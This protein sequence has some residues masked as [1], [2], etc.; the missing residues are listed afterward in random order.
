M[1]ANASLHADKARRHV[2]K[3]R[4]YLAARP[5]LA[6]HNC[7]AIIQAND[8]ERVLTDIDA[9]YGDRN[10]CCRRHSVLLV[11]APLASLSLVGQE[12]GRTIPSADLDQCT[13]RSVGGLAD[14]CY[15]YPDLTI[16]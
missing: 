7:T 9:D 16:F 1:R 8:V 10:L 11:L 3:S 15:P 2:G 4:L 6:Q 5:L 12:H 13:D 14:I